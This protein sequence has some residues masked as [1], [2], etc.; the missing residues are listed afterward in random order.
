MMKESK[1]DC[2]IVRDLLPAYLESLTEEETTAQVKA[3]LE[4]CPSCRAVEQDMRTQVP[5]EKAPQRGLKFLKRVKRTR[6]IA[7]VLSAV[8]ALFCMWWLYDQEFHYANTEAGRLAAVYAYI[9]SPKD[10]F[11]DHGVQA[12]TPLQVVSW[13]TIEDRLFI[14]Y[15]A[16]NE[17]HVHGMLHLVRGINGKYRPLEADFDPSPYAAG[18]YGASLTPRDTDWKLFA[19]AGDDC[20]EIYSAKVRFTGADRMEN[21]LYTAEK[22]YE[23]TGEN[24]LEITEFQDMVRELGWEDQNIDWLYVD[25]V[26]LMDRAGNDIT[27]Q[28]RNDEMTASWGGGKGTAETFLLYVYIGIVALLGVV[29]IRYFLRQ[30]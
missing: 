29:M 20:R 15:K 18:V 25:D 28:Y 1:L 7:A 10:D 5:V 23:L 22:T 19:L 4:D 27:D 6:L 30:D 14:F 3:H 12:G 13:Q 11:M 16:D 26:Q 21:D 24:F 2:C 8:V 17:E 9:T